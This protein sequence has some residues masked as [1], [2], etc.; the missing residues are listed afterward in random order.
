LKRRQRN[1]TSKPIVQTLGTR[2][3]FA[4]AP[5]PSAAQVNISNTSDHSESPALAINSGKL[6]AI[7]GERFNSQIR[8]TETS[9]SGGSWS[10]P[11]IFSSENINAQYMWPDVAAGVGGLTHIVY[12]TDNNTTSSPVYARTRPVGTSTFNARIQ[13]GASDF[14]NP[15]RIAADSAGNVWAVWR[16]SDGTGIFW[17]RSTNNGGSWTYGGSIASQAGNMSYPDIAMGPDNVPHVVWYIRNGGSNANTIRYADWNGSGWSVSSVGD[18]GGYSADPNIVVDPATNIQYLVFRRPVGNDWTIRT[19]TRSPGGAW[20][21]VSDVRTTN[22]DAQYAPMIA[23]D[24]VGAV[25]V[26]WT[27]K[28]GS[29]RDVF[30]S[31]KA[32]GTSTWFSPINVST[33]SGGWNS[34][35]AIVVAADPAA[36]ASGSGAN[37]AHI[38]YQR[39]PGGDQDEI[40]YAPYRSDF[41]APTVDVTDVSPDPRTTGVSSINIVFSEPVSGFGLSNLTLTR[42]G[43]VVAL[44][45]A[46]VTTSDNK[47]FTIS[48]LNTF[49]N[50]NGHYKFSVLTSGGIS[51][52][53]ANTLG[54]AASDEWDNTSSNTAPAI[55]SLSAS[56]QPVNAG[57]SL[58]LT[59]NGVTDAEGD[60]VTVNFYRES[61]G[62]GGLQTGAGGDA[63]LGSDTSSPYS[64][65]VTAPA[66]GSYTYYAQAVDTS[67]FTGTAV[68]TSSTSVSTAP[69]IASLSVAPEPVGINAGVTL[70]ANGVVDAEG[71]AVTVTFYRESNGVAGLQ[72]G[73]GGD[74]S[75][76]SDGTSPYSLSVTSPATPGNYTY[77]AQASDVWGLIGNAASGTSTVVPAVSAT[78]G[79]PDLFGSSDSGDSQTDNLTNRDNGDPADPERKLQFS[80][81][82]VVIGALVTLYAD[83]VAV[84]SGTA[85]GT[86][87]A[88]TTTGNYD[89]ADG[90]HF[91]TARQTESGKTMSAPSAIALKV[92]VD[93]TPPSADV[94]DVAPDPRT[95]A[96]A[97]AALSFGLPVGFLDVSN[98]SLTRNGA[99]VSLGASQQPT[100]SDG[101]LTYTVP[102]LSGLTGTP[103]DYVLTLHTAG[104]GLAD[105]AGNEQFD[106]VADA[107][108][109]TPPPPVLPAW[110]SPAS[111]ATWDDN[112]KLLTV[113]GAAT[114]VA[115]PGA[116]DPAVVASGAGAVIT[117]APTSAADLRVR[118]G[119]LQL[120]N[121]ATATLASLGGSR[122]PTHHRVLLVDGSAGL[123][124]DANSTLDLTDN[125]LVV[126][127]AAAG[128]NPAASVEAMA[129]AGHNG[130]NWQGKRITSSTA[131]AP[132]SAGNFAVAVADNATLTNKF[133]DGTGGKP[134]F[135]GFMAVDDT[136]VLVKYTHRVDLDL[137]GTLNA[138]DAI[139]FSTNFNGGAAHFSAGDL[140]YDTLYTPNDAILFA[141]FYNPAVQQV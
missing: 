45:G 117:I 34:R 136:S 70:T 1:R 60:P 102:N 81:G 27:E 54:A 71:D 141:T 3:L 11:T 32:P 44:T 111:Q 134:L 7:W 61:N 85:Q 83:G 89:L 93:T 67:F 13:L 107:W 40:Y 66:P 30:Y 75:L 125:D 33:N 124:I 129:A 131:A 50:V 122:T 130:G 22:G 6:Q 77:Y 17:A 116:D 42:S 58:T 41:V 80:I 57:A 55:T 5:V 101:G 92:T 51:D 84:G 95:T 68:S 69:A 18:Q 63:V 10:S 65:N 43:N 2:L 46:S 48:G 14:P 120:S 123:S 59:A 21:N 86:I 108:T 105:A 96:I 109:V 8:F 78:P 53:F 64:I 138:N 38:V 119:S 112:A 127:Y 76:G 62:V 52:V 25:H 36:A 82:G 16:D 128:N 26:A 121:G 20:G 97:S 39:G 29:G 132:A 79:T 19:M 47:Q 118:F 94:V 74:A 37:I 12:P 28:V 56:P 115:D 126:D 90:E 49:T 114:V 99:N 98:L 91:F 100:T 15:A 87:I 9:L 24:N 73:G 35:M 4:S 103:G 137:S 72:S 88:I 31:V 133:G 139:T 113:T 106:D 23:V 110:L 140:D 104:L 135:A